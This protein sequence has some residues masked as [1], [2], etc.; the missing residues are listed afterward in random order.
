MFS[1]GL[2]GNEK[3]INGVIYISSGPFIWLRSLPACECDCVTFCTA[4]LTQILATLHLPPSSLLPPPSSSLHNTIKQG[5]E[6]R[7][8]CQIPVRAQWQ[9]L[10]H[11]TDFQIVFNSNV[12]PTRQLFSALT[13]HQRLARKNLIFL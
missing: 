8:F 3:N 5:P 4:T 1:S 2:H 10:F 12:P 11:S 6:L 9:Q 13:H 7:D